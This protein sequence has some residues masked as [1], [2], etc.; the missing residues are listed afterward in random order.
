MQQPFPT[1]F[2]YMAF[3]T[4][5]AL[6]GYGY[7]QHQITRLK[8]KMGGGFEYLHSWDLQIQSSRK[9]SKLGRLV[10]VLYLVDSRVS[11]EQSHLIIPRT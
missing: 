4:Y 11:P 3:L 8:D 6:T 10:K 7:I 5:L 1:V 9:D 2:G